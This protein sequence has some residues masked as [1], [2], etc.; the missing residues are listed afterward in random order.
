ME[1]AL[2]EDNV[3]VLQGPPATF[4]LLEEL[5]GLTLHRNLLE[6]PS[7]G[8]AMIDA[9]SNQTLL[10]RDLHQQAVNLAA[11]L[12]KLGYEGQSAIF[13]ISSE[14]CL[15]FFKVVLAALFNGAV[16]APLSHSYTNY[17]LEHSLAISRPQV[18]FC[19]RA[20][21]PKLL[22]LKEPHTHIK[23]IIVLGKLDAA[24]GQPGVEGLDEFIRSQLG[25]HS[26]DV[27]RFKP[28]EGDPKN[29]IAFIL[30]SSGTTGLPKGVA[31][32]HMNIQVRLNHQREP[33]YTPKNELAGKSRMLGLMP[34]FHAY[35]LIVTLSSLNMGNTVVCLKRFDEDVLLRSIQTHRITILTLVPPLAIFLSK[36]DKVAHYDL[37]AVETVYCAGAPLKAHTEAQLQLRLKCKDCRQAYGMTETSLAVTSMPIGQLKSG[38]CGQV[39]TFLMAKVRDPQSGRSLGPNQVGELCFKGPSILM[40]YY[41]NAKATREAFT[42]DGWFR[43]GDLGY[44]DEEGYFFII[45]RLKEL[46]KY[47]GFQVAPAEL[48]AILVRHPKVSDVGVVGLPDE[49][50][51]E[52]PVA[53][54][55]TK[56]GCELT[57]EELKAYVA[58][59]VSPQKRLSGGVHFVAS[60]PKN[61]S[62]KILRRQ[63]RDWL[64]IHRRSFQSKL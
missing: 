46:I 39:M 31:L 48:E 21:L 8:V 61:P 47:N 25:D 54:V 24:S 41:K 63:L 1:S 58:G 33:L 36:S 42:S 20:V 50:V 40:G 23:R 28:A 64:K 26:V 35:G 27:N 62:G 38:S 11:A 37:S 29:S 16:L 15:D 32:S 12:R 45:D 44:R 9:F 17:E 10:W 49:L 5:L 14:N 22:Q 52:R 30:C 56:E 51:G 2:K 53:F 59:L 13:S 4:P 7:G 55:V 3:H 60:I 57:E 34:F 43:T 6:M 18:V 19:S